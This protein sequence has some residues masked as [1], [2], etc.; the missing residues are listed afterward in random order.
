M[1]AEELAKEA[2]ALA[3]DSTPYDQLP[4]SVRENHL[5]HADAYLRT[6]LVATPFDE[7][8]RAV[9]IKPKELSE[10]VALKPVRDT[11]PLP[12]LPT[13]PRSALRE[14]A[15]SEAQQSKAKPPTTPKPAEPV[16][17]T[18]K[19]NPRGKK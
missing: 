15:E 17:P 16:Q 13:A 9:T 5:A 14:R 12:A 7:A 6:G 10:I 1:T 18:T 2:W 8:C 3:G 11:D 19:P 4:L